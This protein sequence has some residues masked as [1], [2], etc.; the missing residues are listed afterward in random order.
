MLEH[1][2]QTAGTLHNE[3]CIQSEV[4]LFSFCMQ[5]GSCSTLFYHYCSACIPFF[6]KHE[7]LFLNINYVNKTRCSEK[8]NLIQPAMQ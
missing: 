6:S 2:F 7:Q 5:K 4:N 1:K 8:D 3:S